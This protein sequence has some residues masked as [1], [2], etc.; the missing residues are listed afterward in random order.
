MRLAAHH[1]AAVQLEPKK[2]TGYQ[3]EHHDGT[4]WETPFGEEDPANTP[5]Y[6]IDW[7]SAPIRAMMTRESPVQMLRRA[8]SVLYVR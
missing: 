2:T 7:S 4:K 1:F 6:P 3:H 5:W 8:M